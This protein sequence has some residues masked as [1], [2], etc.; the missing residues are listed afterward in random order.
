MAMA[1][2]DD[3]FAAIEAIYAAGL[4]EALWPNALSALTQCVGGVSGT[5]AS[6]SPDM[7]LTEFRSFGTP[8]G[9]EHKYLADFQEINPRLA[10]CKGLR[11]GSLIW[12]YLMLDERG[13]DRDPYYAEFL[14]PMEYRY[15]IAAALPV[16]GPQSFVSV[17]RT[18]KQG[19][20]DRSDVEMMG[21]LGPHVGRALG[22]MRRLGSL[23][24]ARR[25]FE[26][27]LDRLVDGVGLLR[28]DGTLLYANEALQALGSL[29]D[30]IRLKQN[31]ITFSPA[32]AQA[33]F[34]AALAS[35]RDLR[36]KNLSS[37]PADFTVA[38]PSGGPPYLVS[39]RPL[40][41]ER[42]GAMQAPVEVIVFVRD[43]LMENE[44]AARVFREAFGLTRAEAGLAQAL[45]AGVSMTEYAR[46]RSVS[47]TTVYTHMRSIKEKTGCRRMA[48]LIRRLNSVHVPLR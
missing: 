33:R 21:R 6:C 11:S 36:D 41:G 38:R 37:L 5:L 9:S 39:V 16:E 27:A 24:A 43:P 4:D 26:Q 18:A 23:D 7:R 29:N 10:Y 2:A 35:T 13:M 34:A 46:S 15:A 12:D 3:V 25:P 14:A 17:Q 48:E 1:R 40:A 8:L 47:I 44:G 28:A 31:V 45:Q 42:P 20:V 19:H 22:M 30:G 32:E